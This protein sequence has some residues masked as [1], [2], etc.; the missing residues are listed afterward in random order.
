M[1]GNKSVTKGELATAYCRAYNNW[2]LEFCQP[3]PQRL[4][5]VAHI[6]L[7]NVDLAVQEARRVAKLGVKGVFLYAHPPWLHGRGFGDPVN[8]PF[9]AELQDLGLTVGI[10]VN[11]GLD[12]PGDY[13]YPDGIAA[14]RL[15]GPQ[16]HYV[17]HLD[18]QIAF[19]NFIFGG[20]FERFPKLRVLILESGGGWL[21][22]MLDRMDHLNE[23]V[24]PH[25]FTD[26]SLKP[27]EYFQRQC[28]ISIDPDDTSAPWLA[29][30]LGAD[31]LLWASDYPHE[32]AYPQPVEELKKHIKELSEEDQEKI[33]GGN[34]LLA[35]D[36]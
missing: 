1:H 5:P 21:P 36:L 29:S 27:S 35:Y 20:V 31:K 19:T 23:V 24:Y 10:H 7:L 34:A 33:L 11:L 22:A 25:L 15:I 14:S 12:Y 2:L 6:S 32:D 17:F 4:K 18:V 13:I 3:Y 30:Q 26:R 28:W 8:D 9:W 16:V